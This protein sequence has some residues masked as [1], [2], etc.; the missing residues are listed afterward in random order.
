[1]KEKEDREEATRRGDAAYM[2]PAEVLPEDR[3]MEQKGNPGKTQTASNK[4]HGL[5]YGLE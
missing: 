2:W 4:R 3:L 1:M 5:G